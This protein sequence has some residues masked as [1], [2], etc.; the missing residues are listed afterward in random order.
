MERL[1]AAIK[2]DFRSEI[3]QN[4]PKVLRLRKLSGDLFNHTNQH[5]LFEMSKKE[6]S[7]GV[8]VI[9]GAKLPEGELRLAGSDT[10]CCAA[11]RDELK[12]EPDSDDGS[13]GE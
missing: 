11:C 10:A 4:D 7:C 6:L 9:C 8:C 12:L 13:D 5:Q 1:I 2:S 3:T